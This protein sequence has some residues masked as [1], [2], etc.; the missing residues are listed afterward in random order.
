LV[1]LHYTTKEIPDWVW[2]TFWWHDKPNDGPFAAHRPDQVGGV[3]RNYLMDTA[4]SM[5]TPREADGKPHAVY[6]PWL[7]ARF[8][9]GTVSNCMTCHRRA[10]YSGLPKDAAFLP[11]TRG[12]PPAGDA[13]F[14]DATK[15]DFLWSVMFESLQDTP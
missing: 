5:D 8:R 6:N 11:V 13:R 12:T 9:N 7:E 15:L 4:Y 2:A 3:W 14:T 10:I 1:A